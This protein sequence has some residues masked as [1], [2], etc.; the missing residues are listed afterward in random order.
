MDVSPPPHA[1]ALYSFLTAGTLPGLNPFLCCHLSKDQYHL[2][3]T[4]NSQEK[5]EKKKKKVCTGQ[6]FIFLSNESSGYS[7]LLWWLKNG[8]WGLLSF[9]LVCQ[10]VPFLPGTCLWVPRHQEHR[11]RE[12]SSFSLTVFFCT[13]RKSLLNNRPS[14]NMAVCIL[15]EA[16]K[17]W[18]VFFKVVQIFIF[19]CCWTVAFIPGCRLL[20]M[21]SFRQMSAEHGA[22]KPNW[23]LKC[24][25]SISKHLHFVLCFFFSA[26]R[27]N[28][29]GLLYLL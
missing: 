29:L 19:W 3:K 9:P 10:W 5:S 21:N 16:E 14:A 26:P 15:K 28:S 8:G 12:M 22:P 6:E 4:S 17:Y 23:A 27:W 7:D 20:G 1:R 18:L 11:K 24:T 25:R 2:Q 13:A